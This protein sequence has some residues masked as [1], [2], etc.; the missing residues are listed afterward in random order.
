MA[1][2]TI[3]DA[4]SSFLKGKAD[5]DEWRENFEN[6]WYAPQIVDFLG[7]LMNTMPLQGKLMAPRETLLMDKIYRKLRGG[8]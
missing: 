6:G 3:E 5:F 2:L 4:E 8:G 7:T 1:S